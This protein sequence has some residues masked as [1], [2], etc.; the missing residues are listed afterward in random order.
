MGLLCAP[1]LGRGEMVKFPGD[2]AR[3]SLRR[4]P[5]A[6]K[7]MRHMANVGTRRHIQRQRQVLQSSRCNG[8]AR[9]GVTLS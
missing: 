7:H 1:G 4:Y 8:D 9:A 6:G 5:F 2:V 3:A